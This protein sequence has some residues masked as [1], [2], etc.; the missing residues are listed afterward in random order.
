MREEGRK[1][2]RKEGSALPGKSGSRGGRARERAS[3]QSV[4]CEGKRWIRC[5][6]GGRRE[7]ETRT[8]EREEG[9]FSLSFPLYVQCVCCFATV[10]L[11]DP[12]VSFSPLGR[13]VKAV[14]NVM[15]ENREDAA[16]LGVVTRPGFFA[17]VIFPFCAKPW[18]C[19][20]CVT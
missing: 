1:G 7:A 9:A 4:L 19:A 3:E 14:C 13:S 2:G 20:V 10:A 11:I 5:I 8:T 18:P 12:P 16:R 17:F 6:K 15:G